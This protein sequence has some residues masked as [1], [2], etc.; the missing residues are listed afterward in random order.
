MTRRTFPLL[1]FRDDEYPAIRRE[2]RCPMCGHSNGGKVLCKCC[3]YGFSEL[4]SLEQASGWRQQL[5]QCE[6]TWKMRQAADDA[7]AKEAVG[8]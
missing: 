8:A 4:V 2:R 6:Q 3:R 5:E 1:H 7:Q